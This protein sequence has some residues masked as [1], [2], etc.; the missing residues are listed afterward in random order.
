MDFVP[1]SKDEEEKQSTKRPTSRS[2]VHGKLK[3]SER[4]QVISPRNVT[5]NHSV[6]ETERT[7][8]KVK[9]NPSICPSDCRAELSPSECIDLG[10]KIY[11][12]CQ[13]QPK[14]NRLND[15]RYKIDDAIINSKL[16]K[17]FNPDKGFSKFHQ[18]ELKS[19]EKDEPIVVNPNETLGNW[20][21][22]L[23]QHKQLTP[24]NNELICDFSSQF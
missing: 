6:K 8:L 4:R 2:S 5:E 10:R 22:K 17:Y 7:K 12:D 23:I 14:R 15:I 13:G 9:F 11:Q 20:V 1:K 3:P 16:I 19:T 18:I 21:G 24:L